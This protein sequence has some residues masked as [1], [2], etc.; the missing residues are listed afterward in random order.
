MS[1]AHDRLRALLREHGEREEPFAFAGRSELITEMIEV[2]NIMA[3][4]PLK[5]Q[6]FVISGAPGAGKTTILNELSKRAGLPS[7]V[8]NKVPP[9]SDMPNV[10]N[11]LAS[12][13]TGLSL[14]EIRSIRHDQLQLNLGMSVGIQAGGTATK[15]TVVEP[16][17]VTSCRRI[18]ELTDKPLRKPVIVCVDEIQNIR[19]GSSAADFIEELHTQSDIPVLLVCAGL[20][21]SKQRLNEIGVSRST[22]KHDTSLS[23]LKPT[24]SREIAE[25]SLKKIAEVAEVESGALIGMFKQGIAEASDNWPR[26]LTCY[27]EGVC[28]AL[29]ERDP[30]SIENLDQRQV[31]EYGDSLRQ[32]Y[33]Q[34]RLT[35]SEL[36]ASLLN[37]LYERI[38]SNSLSERECV[39]IMAEAIVH[40]NDAHLKESFTGGKHA[41]EQALRSGVLTL[42]ED[43]LCEIPIPSLGSFIGDRATVELTRRNTL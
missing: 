13:L 8:Y 39:N 16:A 37:D 27:L 17:L 43:G 21:D 22:L 6:T 4:R 28:E 10:W 9:D 14:D 38:Q 18:K 34:N 11:E 35:A 20:S 3:G 7:L 2:A 19:E 24:E 32:R 42:S 5:G 36:P 1:R 25:A 41:F 23:A 26:H 33:Y 12:I 15:E 30:P 40:S 29:L 31:L